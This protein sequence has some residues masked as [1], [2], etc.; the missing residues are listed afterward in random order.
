MITSDMVFVFCF[1]TLRT[2]SLGNGFGIYGMLFI[3]LLTLRHNI[4]MLSL[5]EIFFGILVWGEDLWDASHM[6][7]KTSVLHIFLLISM[8]CFLSF[9]WTLR[10]RM[11]TSP[12]TNSTCKLTVLR[13]KPL[14]IRTHKRIRIITGSL[15]T[16]LHNII[17]YLLCIT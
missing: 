11:I 13:V 9:I 8:E 12:E 2:T 16:K 5:P 1:F 15:P 14:V 17:I 6:I 7:W 4:N 3:I 10:H